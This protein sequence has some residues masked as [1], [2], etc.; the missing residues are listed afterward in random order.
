MKFSNKYALVLAGGGAKGAYQI[1][2]WKAFNELGIEF[3][4]VAGASVGA[5]NAAMIAQ[6]DSRKAEELWN[7]ISLEKI[8]CIPPALVAQGKL[9]VSRGNIKHL[10]E[11]NR[12][13]LKHGGLDST[14][15]LNLIKSVLDEELIRK[16]GIDLGLVTFN[17]DKLKPVELFLDSIDRDKLAEYLL[18]SASFPAFKRTT[19]DGNKY[20]DGGIYDNIPYRMIKNRGYRNIIVVDISGAGRNRRPDIIGTRT[21]YIKNSVDRGGILNFNPEVLSDLKTLGYLDTMKVFDRIKGHKYF[22]NDTGALRKKLEKIIS[23][24]IEKIKTLLPQDKTNSKDLLS[25]LIDCSAEALG[26][27]IIKE[28]SLEELVND[29]LDKYRNIRES[30][31]SGSRKHFINF[32]RGLL[33]RWRDSHSEKNIRPFSSFEYYQAINELLYGRRAK[34]AY[35]ALNSFFPELPAALYFMETIEQNSSYLKLS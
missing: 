2:A 35:R 4:A 31:Y 29:I 26:L 22:F 30:K 17:V 20:T 15:L 21:T 11:L 25:S 23:E 32:Y 5:L 13:I 6:G 12:S 18:A 8:V 10:K 7:R 14:P 24:D 3:E 16:K 33:S 19:I 34:T 28:Y 9:Y 1:G 27:T